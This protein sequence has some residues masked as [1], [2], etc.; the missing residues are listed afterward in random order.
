MSEM[1]GLKHAIAFSSG[2]ANGAY[3]AGVLQALFSSA[4]LLEWVVRGVSA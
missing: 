3:A 4:A 1:R 2:G